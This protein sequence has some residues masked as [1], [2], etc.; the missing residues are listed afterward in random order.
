MSLQL[1]GATRETEPQDALKAPATLPAPDCKYKSIYR[2][3][4]SS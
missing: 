3:L 1:S 2:N 4:Y